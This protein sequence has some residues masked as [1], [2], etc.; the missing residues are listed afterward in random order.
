M[1]PKKS[2]TRAAGGESQ[3]TVGALRRD[4]REAPGSIF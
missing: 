1:V 2:L 3:P 4:T